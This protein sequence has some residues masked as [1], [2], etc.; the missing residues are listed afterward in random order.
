MIAGITPLFV[1]NP[2]FFGDGR[3]ASGEGSS[4]GD[5]A[6]DT[7]VEVR[8]EGTVV[9]EIMVPRDICIAALIHVQAVPAHHVPRRITIRV[10][11]GTVRT[12]HP[13]WR[14]AGL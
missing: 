13:W 11:S 2:V 3:D 5:V 9:S 8:R 12:H 14:I 1:A 6:A 7:R 10:L 4:P